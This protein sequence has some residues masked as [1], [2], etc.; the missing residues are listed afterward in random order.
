[1]VLKSSPLSAGQEVICPICQ[2][3]IEPSERC[4]TCPG[5]DQIHHQECWSEVG[6]CGTYGCKQAPTID[7]SESTTAAP[8][9]AWGDTKTCPACGE[10]IKAI[11]LRCRY[12]D[13]EF[14]SVDP[15]SAKDIRKQAVASDK[16]ENLKK[17]VVALFVVALLG[18][19]APLISI[20]SLAYLMPKLDKLNKCGPLF[21]IMGWTSIVLSTL[22]TVLLLIFFLLQDL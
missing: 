4:V 11:A 5:C 16:Q 8:L 17:S 7:K 2:T 14:T 18:C 19:A 22:Y 9:T 13:T 12:C 3:Q 20:I 1:M 21:V 10:Q 15:M 6:G